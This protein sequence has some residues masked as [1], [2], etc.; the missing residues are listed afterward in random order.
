MSK[1]LYTAQELIDLIEE[2]WD[3]EQELRNLFDLVDNAKM[4]N[5]EELNIL[6]DSGYADMLYFAY[7][8]L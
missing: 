7:D 4:K 1:K 3:T 8:S 5:E 2:G 6:R